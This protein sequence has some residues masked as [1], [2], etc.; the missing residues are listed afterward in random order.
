M[1]KIE[2]GGFHARAEARIGRLPL[3][4]EAGE[5]AAQIWECPLYIQKIKVCCALYEFK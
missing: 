4:V 3:F 5:N 1:K 2:V